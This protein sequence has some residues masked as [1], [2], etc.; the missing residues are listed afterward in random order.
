VVGDNLPFHILQ[1]W[2]TEKRIRARVLL[3]AF[4]GRL[5]SL[6]IPEILRH[7]EWL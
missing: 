1:D 5:E 4:A 3:D 6:F 7:D 2:T